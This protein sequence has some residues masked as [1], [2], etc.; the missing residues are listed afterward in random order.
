[1]SRPRGRHRLFWQVYLAF[2]GIAVLCIAAA[3]GTARLLSDERRDIPQALRVGASEIARQLDA[4]DDLPAALRREADRIAME[5]TLR[6]P[7]GEVLASTTPKDAPLEGPDGPTET[8]V[9]KGE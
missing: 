5:L 9:R 4:A 1:M 8:Q 3:G 2:F 6:A 7:S